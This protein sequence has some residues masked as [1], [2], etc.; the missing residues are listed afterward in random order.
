L[1]ASFRADIDN[2]N[3]FAGYSS[4]REIVGSDLLPYDIGPNEKS[5]DALIDYSVDR[6]IAVHRQVID[7]VFA[8][9]RP[10]PHY[11]NPL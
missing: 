5:I 8:C 3:E 4:L 2:A 6:Y 10:T 7:E 11:P 9:W 1:S